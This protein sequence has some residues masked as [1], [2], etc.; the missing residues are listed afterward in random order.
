MQHSLTGQ[1]EQVKYLY[2]LVNGKLFCRQLYLQ[3]VTLLRCFS[4]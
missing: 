1:I 3:S 4:V 2:R